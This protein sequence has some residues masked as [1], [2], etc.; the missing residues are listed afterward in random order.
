[1]EVEENSTETPYVAC[2]ALLF[3]GSIICLLLR[4]SYAAVS[5]AAVIYFNACMSSSYCSRELQFPRGILVVKKPSPVLIDLLL[6]PKHGRSKEHKHTSTPAPKTPGK[7][8]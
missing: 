1:M 7:H 8:A 6:T 4:F 2:F 5:K 3:F